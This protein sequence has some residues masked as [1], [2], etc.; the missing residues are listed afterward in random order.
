MLYCN[1]VTETSHFLIFTMATKKKVC[2]RQE[3]AGKLL[4]QGVAHSTVTAILITRYKVSRATAYRDV[5]AAQ[6]IIEDMQR[7]DSDFGD[8][9]GERIDGDSLV[10]MMEALLLESFANGDVKQTLQAMNAVEKAR[11]MMGT[12]AEAAARDQE[13]DRQQHAPGFK[14]AH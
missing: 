13:S 5:Q 12:H 11:K 10:G 14:S 7:H 2:A 4:Q 8:R 9:I 1:G 3:D 6:I